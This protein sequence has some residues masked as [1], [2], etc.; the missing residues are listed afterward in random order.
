MTG[1]HHHI[2]RGA[3]ALISVLL[4]RACFDQGAG[5]AGIYLADPAGSYRTFVADG[6]GPDWNPAAR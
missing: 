1:A 4:Y 5:P 2:Q 3:A 6:F